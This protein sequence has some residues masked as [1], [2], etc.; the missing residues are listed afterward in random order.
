MNLRRSS[1]LTA[2]L[3]AGLLAVAAC[4]GTAGVPASEGVSSPEPAATAA[5]TAAPADP[6]TTEPTEAP[7]GTPTVGRTGR[8]EIADEQV[9]ITL[10]D[11]WVE[12]VL[13]GDDVE[14]ILDNFP[15]GTFS[16][17]Q[18]AAMQA[19]IG[20]GMKLIAFD[21]DGQGSN[22]NLLIQPTEI[23]LDL[24]ASALEG[25]LAAIP[26]AAGITISETEVDGENALLATY[27]LDQAM[28]DGTAVQ[29]TGTQLY[30]SANGRLYVF[31]V[32]LAD[33]STVDPAGILDTI[34]LLD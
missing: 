21:T 6:A 32:S 29:M 31:T 3:V 14:G 33:G 20:T 18:L 24:L 34:E 2:C 30:I 4:G 12:V 1:T 16:D 11:D 8:I 17:D 26:G 9:A 10:P 22:L 25:Q 7:E 28:A 5:V 19:A 27:D 23:P 13:S 15:D